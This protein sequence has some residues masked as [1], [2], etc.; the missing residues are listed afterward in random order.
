MN[1]GRYTCEAKN[2]AGMAEQDILLYVMSKYSD[3]YR[4]E[5]A[6]SCRCIIIFFA[7]IT[8]WK[9][10]PPN[11]HLPNNSYSLQDLPAQIYRSFFITKMAS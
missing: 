2:K 6:L 4:A 7:P 10:F 1:S 11:G 5:T 9:L 3:V 8:S